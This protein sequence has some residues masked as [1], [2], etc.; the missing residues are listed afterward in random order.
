MVL[1][2]NIWL[3]ICLFITPIFIGG[4]SDYQS[5]LSFELE[6]VPIM[7]D[8]N[9]GEFALDLIVRS[10]S[11]YE[12]IVY[13]SVEDYLTVNSLACQ[14]IER[15]PLALN[16]RKSEEKKVR[17]GPE[18]PFRLSLRGKVEHVNGVQAFD[19]GVLGKVIADSTGRVSF[20]F[21]MYP[22][23]GYF[24]SGNGVASNTVDLSL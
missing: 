23:V 20:R 4:C 22:K 16:N 17:I 7:E 15:L 18:D 5:N 12:L 19:L 1:K 9:S 11:N 10:S 2:A 13:E 24:D 8:L 14:I 3:I 6:V 21:T